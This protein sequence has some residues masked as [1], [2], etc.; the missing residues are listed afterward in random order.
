MR[1]RTVEGQALILLLTLRNCQPRRESLPRGLHIEHLRIGGDILRP[2]LTHHSAHIVG[3]VTS[4]RM[5]V[6]E[7]AQTLNSGKRVAKVWRK[8][9][10]GRPMDDALRRDAE[11]ITPD[12]DVLHNLSPRPWSSKHRQS[13]G[14]HRL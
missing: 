3:I 6:V 11:L 7:V 5:F 14:S 12:Q 8:S 10:V 2:K 9:R 1:S 13:D 4:A